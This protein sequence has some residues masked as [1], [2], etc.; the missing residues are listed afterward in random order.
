[1]GTAVEPGDRRGDDDSICIAGDPEFGPCAFRVKASSPHA[2]DWRILVRV[3]TTTPR[4]PSFVRTLAVALAL[5]TPV[6]AAQDTSHAGTPPVELP[7]AHALIARALEVSHQ[8]KLDE[9]QSAYLV[10]TMRNDSFGFEGKLEVWK[11]RPDRYRL[12]VDNGANW[13]VIESGYSDGIAWTSN[14]MQGMRVLDEAE[15]LLFEKMEAL[16]QTEAKS[17]EDYEEVRT[18]AREE[19]AGVDCYKVICVLRTPEGLE[20]ET[21]ESIRTSYSY[22]EVESGFLKGSEERRFDASGGRS[23]REV[24]ESYREFHGILLPAKLTQFHNLGTGEAELVFEFK[25]YTF[26]KVDDARFELPEELR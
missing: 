12:R 4:T 5:T 25:S 15:K 13:G 26:D 18:I 7:D 1:M 22:Y 23:V 19:F 2:V 16:Y 20:E 11:A 14:P 9:T 21:T 17:D 6:F 8:T 24:I 10:G 3:N